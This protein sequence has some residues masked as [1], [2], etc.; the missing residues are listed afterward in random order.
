MKHLFKTA[1][2]VAVITASFVSFSAF[3]SNNKAESTSI[4]SYQIVLVTKNTVGTNTEWTWQLTNP[5]PGNGQNGTL[6]DVSHWSLALNEQAEAALVS[7]E[8]SDDGVNWNA[9]TTIVERDPSIRSCTGVDVLKYDVGTSGNA[10]KY[11]R[12]N[13]NADFVTNPFATSWIKTGG[14]QQGCNLYYYSGM[15]A[16]L[17]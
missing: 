15:G 11:Y 1:M 3:I 8:Y 4:D 9:A 7:A 2:V 13:F 17:D 10:P 16:R 12:A 5:N 14:G 6:Q